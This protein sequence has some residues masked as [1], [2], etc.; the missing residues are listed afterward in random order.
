MDGEGT[1][2]QA[3]AAAVQQIIASPQME[4]WG[5]LPPEANA[6]WTVTEDDCSIRVGGAELRLPRAIHARLYQYQRQGVA[7]MWNLFQK[8]FG[9]ILADEMGLGKT[10]QAA[11]LLAGLTY[12]KQ[13]SR[14]LV[15]V[16]VTLIEAWRRELSNWVKDLPVHVFYGGAQERRSAMRGL[17]AKGGVLLTSYD[18]VRNGISYLRTANLT[19]ATAMLVKKRKRANNRRACKDDDSPSEAEEEAIAPPSSNE[20]DRM[21]DVVIIDEGHQ[22]K[23]PS[24]IS[25]RDLRRIYSRSRF[26]LTGTPLQNKLS[27]LWTLMDFAQ[28]GLLGNHATFERNFSEQIAKG[29]KRNATRFAVELKDHLARELKRLTAPHFLR[30]MKDEVTMAPSIAPG[31]LPSG[32]KP[33]EL[34]AKMDVVMWCNLT[35]AQKELYEVYLGSEVVRRAAGGKCGLEALRAIAVLKKLCNHPLL[36]LGQEEFNEWRTNILSPSTAARAPPPAATPR[37]T[38]SSQASSQ[39]RDSGLGADEDGPTQPAP[40]CESLMP[41]LRS[42]IPSSM[43]GAALLSCKLRVLSVLLPQLQ[44]RGHRCLIFSHNKRMLD[45]IQAC[46]LRVLGL[47]FLRV[48]GSIDPKDRDQKVSKFQQPDSRY[49]C[50]CLSAGVGGVGLTITG[51][52]RV[53]LVDPA[54]NPAMDAQAIDRTHRIGQ[55]REVVVYRLICAGAIED[56]MFRLQVFKRSLEKTALEQE[57]QLRFFTHKQLKQLFEVPSQSASTQTLMAEQLGTDALEHEELL[58]VVTGDIGS[59]DDP[60]AFQ[61]WQSSD[62]LGFSDYNRL[63]MYLEQSNWEEEEAEEK[64]KEFVARLTSEEYER[65]QVLEGKWRKW[66]ND[67]AKENCSPQTQPAPLMGAGPS[68][69]PPLQDQ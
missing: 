26:L 49:F 13:A 66:G 39:K 11:A 24:S 52:D 34:P 42:L 38:Q 63:F 29:S 40:E 36:M 21:W 8:E 50:M 68:S 12:T 43:E 65:D 58:G 31:S 18:L 20:P 19:C 28:P 37:S 32:P 47:K 48:D 1:Q 15:V 51:A 45:L 6:D 2:Q 5:S 67:S 9:G 46:V 3:S 54:W 41:R 53:I 56:K 14:F 30:R 61:F 25:G 27:D 44:K 22:I 16:P 4:S 33:G 62:V 59:T 55:E 35:E 60:Q 69:P 7:W 64:A 57:Q 23:N 10:V 17:L